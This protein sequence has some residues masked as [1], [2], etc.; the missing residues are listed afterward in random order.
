MDQTLN[1]LC[2]NCDESLLYF[3]IEY[4]ILSKWALCEILSGWLAFLDRNFNTFTY[5]LYC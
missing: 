1:Q 5:L 2:G 3:Y 4:Q